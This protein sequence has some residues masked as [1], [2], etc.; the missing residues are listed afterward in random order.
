MAKRLR[1]FLVL[2][3]CLHL[4]VGVDAMLQGVAWS[5]ML[6]TYSAQAGLAAG[7]TMTFDG[8]HPCCMCKS[9]AGAR[10]QRQDKNE[11]APA[12]TSI[13]MIL[14]EFIAPGNFEAP[15]PAAIDFL[16]VGLVPL[17]SGGSIHGEGPPV[18]PP[19][20]AVV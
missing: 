16:A 2:L 4:C 7:V 5:R 20:E 14:K 17:P 6:V 1:T 13:R 18:P 12:V 19:R 11:E 8:Q 3:S 15:A 9:I 10:Q